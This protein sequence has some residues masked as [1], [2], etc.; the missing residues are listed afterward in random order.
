MV[1][2]R[3]DFVIALRSAFL[4]KNVKQKFSL[5]TLII[6]SLIILIFSNLNLKIINILE[7]G[8]QDIVYRSSLIAS[9]PEKKFNEYYIKVK[10]H[11]N[12]YDLKK[13]EENLLEKYNAEKLA[14]EYLISENNRLREIIGEQQLSQGSII[15]KVLLDKESPFLNSIIINKG[16]K[17]NIELGMAVVKGEYLIG[18]VVEVNFLTSRVILITDINSKIASIIEPIGIHVIVSGN[19]KTQGVIE[20]LKDENYPKLNDE[21]NI[22]TSGVAGVFKAG[23]PIGK[24]KLN[25]KEMIVEFFSDLSQLEFVKILTKENGVNNGEK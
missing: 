2:S 13:E 24:L 20:Y 5:L 12:L 19:G 21:L 6:T 9:I 16:S 3:D 1:K 11:L 25:D 10:D 22:Y 18:K 17:D 15:A 4:K 14:N 23:I 7:K 8:L